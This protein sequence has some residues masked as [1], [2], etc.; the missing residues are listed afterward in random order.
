[1]SDELPKVVRVETNTTT[2]FQ[3]YLDEKTT[4]LVMD[5]LKDA[6]HKALDVSID[7]KPVETIAKLILKTMPQLA[8]LAN[9][10]ETQNVDTQPATTDE[11]EKLN[12]D[13]QA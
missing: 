12:N 6:F 4:N 1:M 3:V 10:A 5:T 2:T 7:K 13:E 11:I 9:R 8:R